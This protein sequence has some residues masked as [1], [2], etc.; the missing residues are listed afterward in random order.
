MR[1]G[2]LTA[3]LTLS[4]LM[5][6][7]MEADSFATIRSE[8][9]G[10]SGGT[11]G[12]DN[13]RTRL[14]SAEGSLPE[15]HPTRVL[16]RAAKRHRSTF[17]AHLVAVSHQEAPPSALTPEQESQ[18]VAD[19]SK[20]DIFRRLSTDEVKRDE[21]GYAPGR[22]EVPRHRSFLRPTLSSTVMAMLGSFSDKNGDGSGATARKGRKGAKGTAQTSRKRSTCWVPEGGACGGTHVV[23]DAESARRYLAN[24]TKDSLADGCYSRPALAAMLYAQHL[25]ATGEMAKMREALLLLDFART[26]WHSVCSPDSVLA[27]GPAGPD[28]TAQEYLWATT[29]LIHSTMRTYVD[30]FGSDLQCKKPQVYT[31]PCPRRLK[32]HANNQDGG[33][34]RRQMLSRL[35]HVHCDLR[36]E[37]FPER[38]V[39]MTPYIPVASLAGGDRSPSMGGDRVLVDFG[40]GAFRGSSKHLI[41]SFEAFAPFHRVV[42]VEPGPIDIPARYKAQYNITQVQ[43]FVR[44]AIG[45]SVVV[46][47]NRTNVDALM[48]I[49]AHCRPEDHCVVK[50]DVDRPHSPDSYEWGFLYTLVSSERVL[51]LVDELY[52]ELHF[53]YPALWWRPGTDWPF[54]F[55]SRQQGLDMVRELRRCG[56]AVH[57]WP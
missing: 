2:L 8:S 50:Y 38:L 42:L 28:A 21:R 40:A 53:Y 33:A 13:G 41:D 57:A 35:E 32:V 4:V 54:A 14:P 56:L 46:V 36:N 16:L 12:A 48:V 7:K 17:S 30:T 18:D 5:V 23:V 39:A 22:E 9:T 10:T 11:N 19:A 44:T 34:A 31:L 37:L 26:V 3:C 25:V 6:V 47:G 49:A 1:A 52:I 55:H 27:G 51:P 45:P 24:D 15:E 43:A 20:L 29:R